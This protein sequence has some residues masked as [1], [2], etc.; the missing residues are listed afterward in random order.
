MPPGAAI[1]CTTKL[2]ALEHKHGANGPSISLVVEVS[3]RSKPATAPPMA[4]AAAARAQPPLPL[5]ENFGG[6]KWRPEEFKGAK[7]KWGAGRG[8]GSVRRLAVAML[9]G[10]KRGRG[11]RR[12]GL[13]CREARAAVA[14]MSDYKRKKLATAYGSLTSALNYPYPN[15]Y[16]NPRP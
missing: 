9:R 4:I 3:R 8:G 16:P 1:Y 10:F 12:L 2:L 11:N 13:S 6:D 7:L 14:A 15:P 5:V